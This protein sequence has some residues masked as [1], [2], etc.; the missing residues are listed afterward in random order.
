MVVG[1]QFGTCELGCVTILGDEDPMVKHYNALGSRIHGRPI[2]Y[3]CHNIVDCEG[4][5]V[6]SARIAMF[7]GNE[8]VGFDSD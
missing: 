6:E 1:L 3:T 4:F 8:Y 2:L 5:G 7:S